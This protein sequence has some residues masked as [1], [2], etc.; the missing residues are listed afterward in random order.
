M[1]LQY[2]SDIR[3]HA[4]RLDSILWGM[5]ES[6]TGLHIPRVEEGLGDLEEVLEEEGEEGLVGDL[7]EDLEEEER[8]DRLQTAVP[9]KL[10]EIVVIVVA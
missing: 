3:P 8:R 10:L 7:E 1:H 5:L 9:I 6:C 2:P 4:E